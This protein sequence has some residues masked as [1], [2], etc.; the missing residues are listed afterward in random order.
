[1][2]A[3]NACLAH[4]DLLESK[5]GNDKVRSELRELKT[6]VY[7]NAANRSVQ[8][9]TQDTQEYLDRL[10]TGWDTILKLAAEQYGPP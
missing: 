6:A 5:D 1:V 4:I 7:I 10:D 3:V 9:H 2:E 8:V